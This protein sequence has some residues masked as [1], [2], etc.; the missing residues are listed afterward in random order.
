MRLLWIDIV[1]IGL[2][3]GGLCLAPWKDPAARRQLRWL[4]LLPLPAAA[5]VVFGPMVLFRYP[6]GALA[7]R[8]MDAQYVGMGVTAVLSMALV[9][10][11]PRV[12]WTSIAL[13]AVAVFCALAVGGVNQIIL[14]PSS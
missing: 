11:L 4:L 5:M 1:L 9:A 7:A 13:G 12:R 6:K 8:L 14:E 2:V 10:A 3:A